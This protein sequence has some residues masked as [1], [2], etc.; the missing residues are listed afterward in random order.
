RVVDIK[1]RFARSWRNMALAAGLVVLIGGG[2]V[3]AWVILTQPMS[4][5][6]EVKT[7]EPLP[8][9]DKPSIAVLPFVNMSGDPAQAYFN[10]G[11][12]EEITTT[13]SRLSN[14][15]VI[16]PDSAFTYKGRDVDL[17]DV[18]EE[19]G[20]RHVLE[21]SARKAN[22]RLQID[23]RLIEAATGN[24]VWSEEFD[25]GLP[26]LFAVHEEITRSVV[27][28]L[29][30]ALAEGESERVWRTSTD[31]LEAY[32]TYLRGLELDRRMTPLA[33]ANAIQ[34]LER[35]IEL[36]PE[37]ARGYTK[38]GHLQVTALEFGWVPYSTESIN[39][40]LALANR[41]IA[42][43]NTEPAAYGLLGLAHVVKRQPDQAIPE[44]DKAI[45]LNPNSST[46][47]ALL[48]I[49]LMHTGRLDEALVQID[50]AIRLNPAPPTWYLVVFGDVYRRMGRFDEAIS[51]FRKIPGQDRESFNARLLL[52]ATFVDVGR[53]KKARDEVAE[54]MRLYPKFSVDLFSSWGLDSWRV[55]YYD[56]AESEAVAKRLRKVGL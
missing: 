22:G 54:L 18:G 39:S 51:A 16:A 14:L 53:E 20:V 7:R 49:A 45:S 12:A 38:L 11:I 23:V 34:M 40:V 44:L 31:N 28:A 33:N 17:E 2:A 26:E 5:L 1:R 29:D 47:K 3:A 32:D 24:Q 35:A 46:V 52:I 8:L 19:L 41:A 27:T 6:T 37:F 43:D 55:I 50:R 36:E 42:L 30:V 21:G 9:P 25:R 10:D 13:L 48:A 4:F 15:F 56:R